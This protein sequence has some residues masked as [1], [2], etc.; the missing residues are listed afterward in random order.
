[1]AKIDKIIIDTQK[2]LGNLTYLKSEEKSIYVNGVKTS[3]FEYNITL[4]SE[5]LQDTIIVSKFPRKLEIPYG[6]AVELV[7]DVLLNPKVTGSGDYRTV[8]STLTIQEIR[9]K[10]QVPKENK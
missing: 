9:V 1:M 7:G 5:G 10:G 4:L 3:D 8:D 6:S 2:T